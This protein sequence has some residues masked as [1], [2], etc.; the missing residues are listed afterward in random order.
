MKSKLAV[1]LG[2]LVLLA[3]AGQAA[4]RYAGQRRPE[5]GDLQLNDG[6]TLHHV[7]VL[8]VGAGSLNLAT[9][10]GILTVARG[11]LPAEFERANLF[12]PE[13]AAALAE[14][15]TAATA[16]EI[17]LKDGRRFKEARPL[18]VCFSGTKLQFLHAGGSEVIGLEVAPEEWRGFI[19]EGLLDYQNQ[20]S[21]MRS[22]LARLNRENA[23]MTAQMQSEDGRGLDGNFLV[24][25]TADA[26]GRGAVLIV[27]TY[28]VKKLPLAVNRLSYRLSS[29]AEIQGAQALFAG[30]DLDSLTA[31]KKERAFHLRFPAG[32]TV[33]AVGWAD[34][35][36]GGQ[37]IS[38]TP[39]GRG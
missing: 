7:R 33:R 39:A 15:K 5:I 1:I 19:E 21:E 25:F 38:L 37:W 24:S 12:A 28:R 18:A 17:T 14:R 3:A 9:N 10:G 23:K 30:Q 2:A 6:R 36:E 16:A 29:G 34:M 31:E 20:Q 8:S 32:Q 22:T 13:P 27:R 26:D 11:L 35:P 4:E